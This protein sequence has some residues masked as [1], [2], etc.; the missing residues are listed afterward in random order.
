[1][2]FHFQ[3]VS[4]FSFTTLENIDWKKRVENDCGEREE[5]EEEC[6]SNRYESRNRECFVKQIGRLSRF[7][8]PLK[9]KI[10]CLG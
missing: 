1:M 7:P 3:I 6:K 10:S 8:P 2:D 5:E 4:S 9:T